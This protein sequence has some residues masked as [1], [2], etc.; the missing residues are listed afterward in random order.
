MEWIQLP[1][2]ELWNG[3]NCLTVNC[4]MDTTALQWTVE[5]VQ[6]PYSELW[7]G[8][9]CLTVD[10]G[11]DTTVLMVSLCLRFAKV[12]TVKRYPGCWH[13][14]RNLHGRLLKRISYCCLG[15]PESGQSH[16]PINVII[17]NRIHRSLS[18]SDIMASMILVDKDN[19]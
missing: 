19:N 18:K 7:N 17:P 4:G 9:N 12:L 16:T 3:Y 5:W 15:W 10:C 6:L 8:Y 13:V 11:M 2:S 1:Y 14:N